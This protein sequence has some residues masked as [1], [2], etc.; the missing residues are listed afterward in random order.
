MEM[1][2]VTVARMFFCRLVRFRVLVKARD[3]CALNTARCLFNR[4]FCEYVASLRKL[5]GPAPG[6]AAA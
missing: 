4:R 5:R 6:A 3:T 2:G 1:Y